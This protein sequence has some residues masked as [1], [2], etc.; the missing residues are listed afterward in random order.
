MFGI[1][2]Q[3]GKARV[4]CQVCLDGYLDRLN[5]RLVAYTKVFGLDY[6]DTSP[7]TKMAFVVCLWLLFS[8]GSYI[9][10]YQKCFFLHGELTKVVY[11][12][13][14]SWICLPGGVF[15][16]YLLSSQI[17]V[18]LWFDRLGHMVRQ[19]G[20]I[21]TRLTTMSFIPNNDT[22]SFH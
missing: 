15:W 8:T 1:N 3:F 20:M 6:G 21:G 5:Y 14:I 13:A 7:V 22:C 12:G 2:L 17:S 10:G 4:S 18:W 19:F 9:V 11:N 16:T